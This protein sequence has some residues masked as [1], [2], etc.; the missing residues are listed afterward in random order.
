M[1]KVAACTRR[2]NGRAPSL[3]LFDHAD[4]ATVRTLP[5]S[6]RRLARRYG[7]TASTALAV[8]FAAGLNCESD[9]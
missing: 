7:L 6:A 5:L 4:R 9:R 3:L 1:T 8:A 2:R